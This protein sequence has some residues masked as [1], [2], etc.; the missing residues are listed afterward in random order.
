VD[1]SSPLRYPRYGLCEQSRGASAIGGK[2]V[3]VGVEDGPPAVWKKEGGG[4]LR[5]V[6]TTCPPKAVPNSEPT[7]SG[8]SGMLADPELATSACAS[9][10]FCDIRLS[11]RARLV[12]DLA[13]D[14]IVRRPAPIH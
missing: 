3:A 2:R 14:C 11:R 7:G 9:R 1:L 13:L 5:S 12:Y 4:M 8:G 6:S 10:V